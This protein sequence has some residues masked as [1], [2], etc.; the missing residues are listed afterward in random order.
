MNLKTL[1]ELPPWEWPQDAAATVLRVLTD[2][3]TPPPELLLAAELAGDVTIVN[4]EL[5]EALLSIACRDDAPVDLRCT[6][7]VALGPVLESED[8]RDPED[9]EDDEMALLSDRMFRRI[10]SLL[11]NLCR[12]E[13]LTRDVRR[14]ALE[15]SI[16]APQKW[17][18]EAVRDAYRSEDPAWNLTAVF[19]MRFVRGFDDQILEALGSEDAE[20]RYEAVCAAG[21][22]ELAAAWPHVAG[23]FGSEAVD[24]RLLLAA[25]EAAASIRPEEA[26]GILG[27]LTE[28][29]DEE[30]AEAAFDALTTANFLTDWED[31]ED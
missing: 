28:S 29:D 2:E 21:N 10:Q 20:V 18:R 14:R 15:A 19:C 7:A 25:I 24:K 6:A 23:L 17:H 27:D 1:G 5:A 16:R 31:E 22:R 9:P 12:T 8:L 4:D 3:S 13:H 26:L 30:I 11:R